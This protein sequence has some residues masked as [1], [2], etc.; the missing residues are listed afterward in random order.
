MSIN[1]THLQLYGSYLVHSAH[2][3]KTNV[4]TEIMNLFETKYQNCDYYNDYFIA[5]E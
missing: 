5:F 2:T 4:I 3:R 1:F